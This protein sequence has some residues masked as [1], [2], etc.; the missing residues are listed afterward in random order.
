M[1]STIVVFLKGVNGEEK[2]KR[3]NN[4]VDVKK[5]RNA[6]GKEN[7]FMKSGRPQ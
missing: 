2:D 3:R 6:E 5:L 4:V 7:K 1:L